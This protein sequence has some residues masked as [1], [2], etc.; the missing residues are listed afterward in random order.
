MRRA[1]RSEARRLLARLCRARMPLLMNRALAVAALVVAALAAGCG[2]SPHN[3]AQL[4]IAPNGDELH[5]KL[6]PI[7]PNPF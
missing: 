5:V 4:W 7:E 1:E 3:P 2:G 6:Q